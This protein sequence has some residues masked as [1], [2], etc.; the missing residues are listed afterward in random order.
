MSS[1]STPHLKRSTVPP[2]IVQSVGESVVELPVAEV[3][4]SKFDL[5]NLVDT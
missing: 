3:D 1:E 2:S 5:D 4:K